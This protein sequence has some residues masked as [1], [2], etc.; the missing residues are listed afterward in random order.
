MDDMK[1]QVLESLHRVK[2]M[3][4]LLRTHITP[5]TCLVGVSA[6]L[7]AYWL[8]KRNKYR[9]PPGPLALPLVGNYSLL[10]DP[11][12]HETCARLSEK[13]GPVITIQFG[14]MQMVILNTIEA[15]VEAMV[16]KG[17]DFANR[18]V[19]ISGLE[20]SE[21]GKNIFLSQYT[22]TWKLHRK[23][24][25]KALRKYLRGEKPQTAVH[26]SMKEFTTLLTNTK[27]EAF[28][29]HAYVDHA[30]FNVMCGLCFNKVYNFNNDT[31]KKFMNADDEFIKEFGHGLIEDAF[32]ILAKIWPSQQYRK[33]LGYFNTML[34]FLL[35]EFQEHVDQFDSNEIRDIT[36][37]V[38]LARKEAEDEEDAELLSQLTDVHL[39]QTI[40]DLFFAGFETT[41]LTLTWGLLYL[42][43]HQ[44]VQRRVQAEVDKVVGRD[45]LP[46]IKDRADLPYTEAVIY[47]VMRI[48]SVV[49]FGV[50]HAARVDSK[51]CGYDI[52]QG[53]TV[54]INHWALHNDPRH[55]KQPQ[56]FNPER[57]LT[58][59]GKLAPPPES[60]LPFS[61]GKRMCLG[62][63]AAKQE[64]MLIIPIILQE[65]NIK[66]PPGVTADYSPEAS[67]LTGYMANRYLISVEKRQ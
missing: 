4:P 38:I 21:G 64:L 25:T 31:F 47:E 26:A 18:P 58:S 35:D 53:T 60:F 49:P 10:G 14:P 62:E 3:L 39:R 40:A 22:P 56:I 55:W 42:A 50:A 33:V 15:V 8:I 48:A 54:A 13:Y 23:L 51:I 17:A 1:K 16:T 61:V 20:L 57:F 67:G 12:L 66:L 46:T 2:D 37:F 34:Q 27:G 5:T 7:A 52:P 24:A 32:P 6:G 44:E 30:L 43:D 65:F 11:M 9:L 41:R 45:R 29:P 63:S 28:T 59:E 19:T 36:D